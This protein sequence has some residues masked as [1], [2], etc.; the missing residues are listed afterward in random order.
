MQSTTRCTHLHA[1]KQVSIT[2]MSAYLEG[3]RGGGVVEGQV[4]RP[5]ASNRPM[6]LRRF[7]H[8]LTRSLSLAYGGLDNANARWLVPRN[9]GYPRSLCP[10]TLAINLRAGVSRTTSE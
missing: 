2:K 4:G 7:A 10:K 5:A 9:Q 8:T 6:R 3:E 1:Q